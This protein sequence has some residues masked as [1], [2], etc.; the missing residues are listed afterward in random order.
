MWS[1][2]SVIVPLEIHN[3][4]EYQFRVTSVH[5]IYQP[6]NRQIATLR[7][8][9]KATQAT[10]GTRHQAAILSS[11]WNATTVARMARNCGTM[12]IRPS[13]GLLAPKNIHDHAALSAS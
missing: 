12:L 9:A 7:T 10:S 6:F 8:L 13:S 1:A 5:A 4:S 2:L 3:R 11:R